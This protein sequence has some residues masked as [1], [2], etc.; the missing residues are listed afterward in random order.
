VLDLKM[1]RKDGWAVLADV[2]SD[3][4]LKKIPLIIFST[5]ESRTDIPRYYDMGANSYIAKPLNL[6]GYTSTVIG[7]GD[8]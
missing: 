2:K 3:G 5:S 4:S 7:I 8:Y 1:P 6:D